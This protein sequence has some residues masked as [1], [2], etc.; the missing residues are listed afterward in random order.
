MKFAN[1]P[2]CK[3]T[4]AEARRRLEAT[5]KVYEA[6][7][8]AFDAREHSEGGHVERLIEALVGL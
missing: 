6:K 3:K 2:H 8:I 4:R 1:D 7:Q 5:A